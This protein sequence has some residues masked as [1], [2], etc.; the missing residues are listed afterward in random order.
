MAPVRGDPGAGYVPLT[1]MQPHP[2]CSR[3]ASCLHH[4]ARELQESIMQQTSN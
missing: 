3:T 1:I 4:R 2:S